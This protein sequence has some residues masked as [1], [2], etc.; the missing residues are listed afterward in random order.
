MRPAKIVAI[1]IGVLL[2]LIGLALLVPGSILLWLN[3]AGD[4]QGY[5][6]HDHPF[7]R[8][9]GYALV[10]P[11]V[12]LDLGSGDW[13]PGEGGADPGDV[14]RD[15]PFFVGIGP[16]ADVA[17]YLNGV[18]YDEVTNLGWFCLRRDRLPDSRGRRPA[19]P[20][21][22]QTFWAAKQEGPGT[23]SVQ[24]AV[25]SGNWTAVLMNADGS[26]AGVRRRRV[27]GRIWA[28]CCRSASA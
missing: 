27:L 12:K 5:C 22:Q 24:W 7:P 23:Q 9:R 17:D 2:I 4:S 11:D 13:I 19:T 6:Q 18:A 16:T 8:V 21:G 14:K 1:V 20:P 25:Q 28:S 26:R 3:G 15:A 10:T